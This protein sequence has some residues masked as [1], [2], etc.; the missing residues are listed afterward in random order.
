[1]L[2]HLDFS[3]RVA[4]YECNMN[5]VHDHVAIVKH[6]RDRYQYLFAYGGHEKCFLEDGYKRPDDR[7]IK[8]VSRFTGFTGRNPISMTTQ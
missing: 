5:H 7:F 3:D 6:E 1:M 4:I 8:D 2:P